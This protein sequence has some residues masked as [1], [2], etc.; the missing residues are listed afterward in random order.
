MDNQLAQILIEELKLKPVI[1]VEDT[2]RRK[3]KNKYRNK[4]KAIYDENKEIYKDR[5]K[6][7]QLFGKIKN[8]YGDRDNTKNYNL[9]SVFVLIRFLIYNIAVLLSILLYIL[10][11]FKQTIR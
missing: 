10:L 11:F 9:A 3:V 2:L 4:I 6:I 1:P 7:E 8:A 5:Y